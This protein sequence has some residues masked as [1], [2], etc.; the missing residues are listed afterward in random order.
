MSQAGRFRFLEAS[1]LDSP[2]SGDAEREADGAGFAGPLWAGVLDGTA[3]AL[4]VAE[5]RPLN[6]TVVGFL[7]PVG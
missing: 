6:G 7:K 5:G 3:R 1:S 4:T 2:L